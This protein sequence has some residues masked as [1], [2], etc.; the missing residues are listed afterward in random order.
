MVLLD[1]KHVEDGAASG[2]SY[3]GRYLPL[4]MGFV[5]ILARRRSAIRPDAGSSAGCVDLIKGER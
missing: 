3:D 5:A 4:H 2:S 1:L